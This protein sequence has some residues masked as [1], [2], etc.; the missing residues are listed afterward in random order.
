MPT[1]NQSVSTF[2]LCLFSAL[3]LFGQSAHIE[4]LE[5]PPYSASATVTPNLGKVFTG[6]YTAAGSSREIQAMGALA[7][8]EKDLVEIGLD[9]T[10]VINVR[11]YLKVSGTDPEENATAMA[12]WNK[13]FTPAFAENTVPPTRTTFG[14]T[15]LEDPEALIAVEA[16][17][18]IDTDI[19]ESMS[20]HP[21]NPR[22]LLPKEDSKL[23]YVKPFSAMALTSGILAS[24][25]ADGSMGSMA[26]QTTNALE[27][28][29]AALNSW[30]LSATDVVYIR[31]LLSPPLPEDSEDMPEVDVAGYQEA[32]VEFWEEQ[33][34]PVPPTAVL[35]APGFNTSGRLVEIEFYAAFPDGA[36]AQF[37]TLDDP[38]ASPLFR[39]EGSPTSFLNRS[40]IIARDA[41]MVWFAGVIDQDRD[42]IHGQAV[43][44]LLNIQERMATAGVSFENIVQLRAYL[45]I[46]NGFRTDFGNWNTAYKRFFNAPSVNPEKPIRTAFPV[47]SIPGSAVIEIEAIGVK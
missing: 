47:K 20:E 36:T 8:M 17:L 22:I 5:G 2:V 33:Y 39:R 27:K 40:A 7:A 35:A 43:E 45:Q 19:S 12:E 30:G 4:P 21:A 26:R 25:Q 31:S 3:S 34:L 32:Y 28:L 24:A 46:E 13:A 44:S 14:V 15:T 11:G 29:E 23:S 18:A 9:L 41:S 10:D 38:E 6:T 16:V 42:N 1:H 37:S